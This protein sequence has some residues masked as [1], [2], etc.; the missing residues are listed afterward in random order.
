MENEKNFY[1]REIPNLGN[2]AP[3]T[4][5]IL[6]ELNQVLNKGDYLE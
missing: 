6:S 1:G 2:I 4:I 3:E 5:K